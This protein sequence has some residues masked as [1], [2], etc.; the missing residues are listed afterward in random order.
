VASSL[1]D[2]T[3]NLVPVRGVDRVLVRSLCAVQRLHFAGGARVRFAPEVAIIGGSAHAVD[4]AIED[5]PRSSRTASL[6]GAR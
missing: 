6:S 5:A 3:A 4:P 2:G 1:A